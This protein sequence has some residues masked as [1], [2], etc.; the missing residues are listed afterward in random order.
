MCIS[1]SIYSIT[2]AECV[3]HA[4][5]REPRRAP[6]RGGGGGV[7]ERVGGVG[8]GEQAQLFEKVALQTENKG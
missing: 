6:H 4:V 2:C 5:E 7:V 1:P 3:G 8:G